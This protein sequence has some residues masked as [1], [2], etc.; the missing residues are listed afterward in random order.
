MREDLIK[1]MYRKVA[2]AGLAATMLGMTSVV[3]YLDL[4]GAEILEAARELS[5]EKAPA[6]EAVAEEEGL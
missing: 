2:E 4:A 5:E 3:D 1:E 6:A